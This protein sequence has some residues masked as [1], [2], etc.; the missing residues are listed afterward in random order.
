MADTSHPRTLPTAPP[1]ARFPVLPDLPEGPG[2][3]RPV[4]IEVEF[5]ALPPERAAEI[6][7]D[8]F[9]GDLRQVS[10]SEWRLEGSRVGNLKIYLDSAWRPGGSDRAAEMGVA[11]ARQVVPIEIVTEPLPQTRLPE[12]DALV[13]ELAAA[14]AEGSR[15]HLLHGFGLHLN[16]ALADPETGRDLLRVARAFALLEDWLRA[17]DP[18]D[19]SRRVLP[20]TA[21]FPAAFVEALAALAP[22]DPPARLFDLIDAH[23]T[24]RNHGLDLMPAYAHLAP[25]RFAR[26]A[27]AA[28][29]AVA[30]R[31]AYHFRMP[32]SRIGEPEWS[33]SYDWR[34]WWLVERVA[35]ENTLA[36]R[37]AAARQEAAAAS[38]FADRADEGAPVTQALGSFA[39]LAPRGGPGPGAA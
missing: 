31:P 10:A 9:G 16:I 30:A 2:A 24:S 20:F 32:E 28:A 38:P 3:P 34:R 27:A 6:C 33:L 36:A 22:S 37:V 29:G 39:A 13:A 23:L 4:G 11:V 15:A 5:G 8:R 21:P 1:A 25:E 12:I 26:H 7:E 17:R 14:G 19:L 18:L 35:S